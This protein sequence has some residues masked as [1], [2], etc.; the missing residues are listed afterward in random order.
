MLH[1]KIQ[2]FENKLEAYMN[3]SPYNIQDSVTYKSY[4][5]RSAIYNFD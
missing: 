3:S 4:V 2:G 5:V 1:N